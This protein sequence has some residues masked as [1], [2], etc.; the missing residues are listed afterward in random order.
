MT[1][2]SIQKCPPSTCCRNQNSDNK[3]PCFLLGRARAG[4][5][6]RTWPAELKLASSKPAANAPIN[7]RFNTKQLR[8][9][10]DFP[11]AKTEK[12]R[13]ACR[14]SI[15]GVGLDCFGEFLFF[16]QSLDFGASKYCQ[17][18]RVGFCRPLDLN[19]ERSHP[20]G[21]QRRVLLDHPQQLLSAVNPEFDG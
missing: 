18:L 11:G 12:R 5:E 4:G 16:E 3:L 19:R 8:N 6:L 14:S 15:G 7:G 9:E 20:Y 1:S 21:K 17:V 10:V 2:T 13:G